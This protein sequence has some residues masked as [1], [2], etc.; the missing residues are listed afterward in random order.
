M[1]VVTSHGYSVWCLLSNSWLLLSWSVHNIREPEHS[2]IQERLRECFALSLAPVMV[3]LFDVFFLFLTLGCCYLDLFIRE[4]EYYVPA[5]KA[6]AAG[7]EASVKSRQPLPDEAWK[8]F[9]ILQDIHMYTSQ[10]SFEHSPR[11]RDIL[12][13]QHSYTFHI[14]MTLCQKKQ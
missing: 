1:P 5:Y 12:R 11:R 7:C 14:T 6:T 10:P 4:P 8:Y 2:V 9:R 13:S 3:S